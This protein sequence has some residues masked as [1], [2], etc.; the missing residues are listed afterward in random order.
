MI[1]ALILGAGM[2]APL[3][4]QPSEAAATAASTPAP[5]PVITQVTTSASGQKPDY[6]IT[7]LQPK[8]AD[9]A[10]FNAAVQAII[11]PAVNDFKKSVQDIGTTDNGAPGTSS[12]LDMSYDVFMTR[13][14]LV[15]IRFIATEYISGAAHPFSVVIT[16]N[17]DPATGKVLKLGD[18][19]KPNSK[20]LDAIAKICI[21][22]LKRENLLTFP[23][24]AAPTA[25]NYQAWSLDRG[26]LLITFNED[27]VGPH[28]QGESVVF[29]PY[30]QLDMFQADYWQ[31][32]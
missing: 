22:Q 31:L 27:Q 12:S 25:D 29:I 21:D 16:L 23:D 13:K 8:I 19:F 3:G 2:I 7:L 20:Y 14:G 4:N 17:Y 11:D 15:S 32:W 5:A 30:S 9:D 10:K 28:A 6:T 26:G 24:G 1:A 18:L